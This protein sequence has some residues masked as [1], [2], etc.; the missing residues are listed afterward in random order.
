MIFLSPKY[1]NEIHCQVCWTFSTYTPRN[2]IPYA[3]KVCLVRKFSNLYWWLLQFPKGAWDLKFF[4]DD[5]S[6][7]GA[8]LLQFHIAV[9]SDD[10]GLQ[11]NVTSSKRLFLS[12]QS[13]VIVTF[14]LFH[15]YFLWLL[16]HDDFLVI[17]LLPYCLYRPS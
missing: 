2:K 3:F 8:L 9:S 6:L 5:V 1:H 7:S 11:L 17:C 16:L 10:L 14:S 4:S 13:K 15:M 12:T